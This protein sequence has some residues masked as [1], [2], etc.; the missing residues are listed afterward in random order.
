MMCEANLS[1]EVPEPQEGGAV[2]LGGYYSMEPEEAAPHLLR[3][4]L[5]GNFELLLLLPATD[6]GGKGGWR[7]LGCW[8]PLKPIRQAPWGTPLG[9]SVL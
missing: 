2:P 6:L 7:K 1:R 5:A 3:G 4:S 8:V 9:K